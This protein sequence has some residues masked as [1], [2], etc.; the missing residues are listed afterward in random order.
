MV[1]SGRSIRAC[2]PGT[3]RAMPSRPGIA[4]T[5]VYL[6]GLDRRHPAGAHPV[7]THFIGCTTPGWPF[8]AL[9]GVLC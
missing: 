8:G 4:M 7:V 5:L 9:A 2:P 6:T 1:I 3:V